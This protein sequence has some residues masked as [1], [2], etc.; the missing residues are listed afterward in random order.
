MGQQDDIDRLL[1][2]IDAMNSGAVQPRAGSAPVPRPGGEP[3]TVQ[4]SGSTGG[5]LAWTGLSAVGGG[6]AGG[7]LGTILTMLPAM[8]TLSTAV[9]A[10]LGGAL[11]GFVSGPPRWFDQD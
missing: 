4:S 3:A 8:G 11:V 1:R 10:A 7:V 2:E 9:G 5:R 6:L